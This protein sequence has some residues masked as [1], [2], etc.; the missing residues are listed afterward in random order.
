M[1]TSASFGAR[2]EWDRLREAIVGEASLADLLAR[3]GV[4]VRRP[5][6]LPFPRDCLIVAGDHLI[7]GSL[8]QAARQGERFAV[9]AHAHDH[10]C[11]LFFI[12]GH[13]RQPPVSSL[14]LLYSKSAV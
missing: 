10:L 5:E 13:P 11:L 9:R 6:S 4:T 3:E 2:Y 1:S 8:R 7:E 14:F 12:Q